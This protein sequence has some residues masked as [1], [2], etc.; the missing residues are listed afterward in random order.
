MIDK[1][2]MFQPSADM[3][4]RFIMNTADNNDTIQFP[5]D[6]LLKGT[7]MNRICNENFLFKAFFSMPL[8]I[9]EK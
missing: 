6:M 2:G 7:E 9:E 1:Y 3:L 8:R 4:N 5:K